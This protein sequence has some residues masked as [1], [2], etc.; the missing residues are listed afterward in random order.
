MRPD[1]RHPA[2]ASGERQNASLQQELRVRL[3]LQEHGRYR[4]EGDTLPAAESLAAADSSVRTQVLVD[5]S[6]EIHRLLLR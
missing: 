6:W 5:D 4:G 2:R 3:K 1:C